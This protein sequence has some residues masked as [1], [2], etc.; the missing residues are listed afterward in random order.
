MLV[1]AAL[2]VLGIAW[3]SAGCT[4]SFYRRCADNEVN[5]I[6]SEKNRYPEWQIEQWHVYP[7]SRARFADPAKPDR[8]P[9]P[10]DDEAA[11]TMSPH[12]Q[13]PPHA[14]V[15]RGENDTYLEIMKAWDAQNRAARES[16]AKEDA[17][18]P[19]VSEVF[20]K[21]GW[22]IQG[23]ID[24]PLSEP[25]GFLLT[26]EQ[27]VELGVI[28]SREYQSV[29]EDLYLAALPV[30]L[31]RFSFAWQWAAIENAIRQFAGPASLVG[32]QNN[33]SLG[34]TT[35]VSKLF[36]TGALLTMSFANTSIFNF[37]KPGNGFSS[38]SNIN[39]NL[40]QPLLQGGGKAVTLEPLTQSERNL[41]YVI[42]G[43]GHFREQF[44]VSIA[45]GSNLNSN[46][47]TAL[48]SVGGGNV[49]SALAALGIASTDVQGVFRGYLPSL[50]RSLDMAVDV[51]YVKDLEK[52]LLLFE[53]FQEGGQV[54]PLQV[55]QVRSTLLQARN[56]VLS[57]SQNRANSLD[58]FK[59]QMGLPA[60][61]PLT[62][63]DSLARPITRVLDSYYEVL[64][65][66]DS[67]NR[68]I[69]AQDKL[70]PEKLRAFLVGLYASGPIAR[71]TTFQKKT[72]ASLATWAKASD[73]ELKSRM[74]KLGQERRQ[75][76]DLKTEQEMKGKALAPGEA[77]RLSEGEFEMDVG[78]LEQILRRYEAKPWEKLNP[79]DLRRQ[80]RNKIFRF[81]SYAAEIVL[82]YAR[83]ERFAQLRERWPTVPLVPIENIDLLNADVE[84][85]QEAAVQIAQ[86][87]R[88]D[89]MNARTQ[90]VDAW[91][92]VAVTAN[93]LLG[94]LN[95]QYHLDSTTPPGGTRPLAFSGSGTNQEL[96]INA[97]L[98]LVRITERNNYRTALINYERARRNLMNVEDNIAAQ[99]RF[100]VRQLHLFAENYKIEQKVV[101]SLYSQVENALEVLV[102]PVDPTQ[103]QASTTQAAANAAALTNQYLNAL[104]GLNGAQ[105]RMYDIWLSYLAT[106][107]QLYVDLERLP[108]DTR[109]VW[110][111][112]PGNCAEVLPPAFGGAALGRPLPDEHRDIRPVGDH[113]DVGAQRGTPARGA[114]A[115][116]AVGRP[117]L[118]APTAASPLE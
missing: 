116:G 111:D 65:Q 84:K 96:I 39:V 50:F 18:A 15:R 10:P 104:Q 5:D 103:L 55:E 58:Q 76:L 59:I 89:L 23:L 64:A 74:E 86:R 71:G 70:A 91:R 29:R 47:L 60:N 112:E 66:A 105:T 87:N 6:L 94:V 34:S 19:G 26:L 31:Q 9:M 48:N 106:R 21:Q 7:D 25:N 113:P 108:L 38:V 37:L 77:Q 51:K 32:P 11:W 35:S 27:A 79:E 1:F 28:N 110:I 3:L 75:L 97:Q 115:R 107:M 68:L 56:T 14:G 40:V 24:G 62:L 53:G 41:I 82:V 100:D 85:A 69:D 13:H 80:E 20:G 16:A 36:S 2:F 102:A 92:Q 61:L 57:D 99:V 44:Y 43:Y 118:L 42:R 98:P 46:L 101:E 72:P 33:W 88:W 63:D 73:K 78:G 54:A 81:V 17:V 12:P 90:V 49:I 22:S 93:A 109:G 30:T 52:G 95:V 117:R 4:R 67:A 45:I 8:P 83:N 114:S